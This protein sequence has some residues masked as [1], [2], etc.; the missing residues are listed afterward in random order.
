MFS[1]DSLILLANRFNTPYYRGLIPDLVPGSEFVRQVDVLS[2]A[3]EISVEG[4]GLR[5]FAPHFLYAVAHRGV[6]CFAP[7]SPTLKDAAEFH[8]FS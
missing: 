8:W 2:T 1:F 4:P 3:V 6:F 5:K 7:I